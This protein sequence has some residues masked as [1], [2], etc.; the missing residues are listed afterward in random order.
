MLI[1]Q[2]DINGDTILMA[3]GDVKIRKFT[4]PGNFIIHTP[5]IVTFAEEGH[6]GAFLDVEAK[7]IILSKGVKL[8]GK[9][10]HLHAHEKMQ[11]LGSFE[12]EED[13]TIKA[14]QQ[15][16]VWGAL[17]SLSGTLDFYGAQFNNGGD[18]EA[19]KGIRGNIEH[20]KNYNF[21]RTKGNFLLQ[22][23]IF[24][25]NFDTNK[26]TGARIFAFGLLKID[27]AES[28]YDAGEIYSPLLTM[29]SA[30]SIQFSS[31][32][33]FYGNEA[34]I[35]ANTIDAE[36]GAQ[37]FFQN[38]LHFCSKLGDFMHYG[39]VTQIESGLFPC[40]KDYFPSRRLPVN[41]LIPDLEALTEAIHLKEYDII[42]NAIAR[43]RN[44]PSRV[45]LC[46]N[47]KGDFDRKG[48]DIC[49]SGTPAFQ[50]AGK[51]NSDKH[52]ARS[53][54][55]TTDNVLIQA[56]LLALKSTSI[57]S[58]GSAHLISRGNANFD[59]VA[60][61]ADKEAY[62]DVKNQ[63]SIPSKLDVNGTEGA[64]LKSKSLI[65]TQLGV[66]SNQG[67]ANVETKKLS[68]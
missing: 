35:R 24:E 37:F 43:I 38:T 11:I 15:L 41:L 40:Y 31:T 1:Y 64:F 46:Y 59:E 58:Y 28:Y 26:R 25:N 67:V 62:V 60:V 23:N 53:G 17:T 30:S 22:T 16:D 12:S 5:G 19:F 27:T 50:V 44:G 32:H 63:L 7:D 9:A 56:A 3:D 61:Q 51:M 2:K 48:N 49:L 13:A 20:F 6:V 65:G 55:F 57:K 8:K 29:I 10:S 52:L 47:V 18:V 4:L 66:N 42:Q 45:A 21:L 34:D 54:I 14:G 33:K 39:D 36:R 68:T